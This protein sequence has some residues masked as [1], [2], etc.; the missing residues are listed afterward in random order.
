MTEEEIRTEIRSFLSKQIRNTNIEDGDDLFTSGLVNSMFAMELVSF[1]EKKFK[2]VI[3][4]KDLNLD[5][6]TT[7][8]AITDLI[9]QKPV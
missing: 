2:I 1:V 5:N 9:Q 8:N 7:I 4:N 3:A 6:F